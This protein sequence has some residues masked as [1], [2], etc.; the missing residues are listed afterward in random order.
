M[1]YKKKRHG[2]TPEPNG[3]RTITTVQRNHIT[4]TELAERGEKLRDEHF[5]KHP[6]SRCN[7]YTDQLEDL[8]KE[9]ERGGDP[10]EVLMKATAA[11]FLKGYQARQLEE[12]TRRHEEK[13]KAKRRARKEQEESANEERKNLREYPEEIPVMI[14]DP[15]R[16]RN[17]IET[18]AA[19]VTRATR[20]AWERDET[21]TAE[22]ILINDSYTVYGLDAGERIPIE[23]N[24]Q[25]A[26]TI[27][28][29]WLRE[30]ARGA[31][32]FEAWSRTARRRSSDE[33]KDKAE[34]I[35]EHIAGREH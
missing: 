29:A 1:T 19:R 23:L 25:K 26:P 31:L 7:V 16:N 15:M 2:S 10:V 12:R 13:R 32:K 9:W 3:G 34:Y 30:Y 24:G 14:A 35:R 17:G 8:L 22:G 4:G 11:G 18:N 28:A 20:R 5:T 33:R 6:R 21:G 27:P